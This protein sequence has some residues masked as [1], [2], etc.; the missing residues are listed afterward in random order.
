MESRVEVGMQDPVLLIVAVLK[1]EIADPM[2]VG[3][4]ACKTK[5]TAAVGMDLRPSGAAEAG[6]SGEVCLL[7]HMQQLGS[8]LQHQRA[9]ERPVWSSTWQIPVKALHPGRMAPFVSPPSLPSQQTR[10]ASKCKC[11]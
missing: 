7:R 8:N 6:T 9:P 4:R 11:K 2:E 1:V 3:G 5:H 10:S